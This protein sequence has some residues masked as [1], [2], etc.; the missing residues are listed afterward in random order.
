MG[1]TR[2][3]VMATKMAMATGGNTTG[4]GYHCLPSSVA[5]ETAVGKDDK[6]SGNLFLYGVVV[7]KNV[8][9]G[10]S[11][12]MFG[13]EAVCPDGLFCSCCIPRVRFLFEQS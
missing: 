12:F 2:A 11:I 5:V 13:K 4:S 7:K 10:F 3:M 1:T 8:L 9:C 6:S